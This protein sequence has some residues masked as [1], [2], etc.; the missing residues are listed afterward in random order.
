MMKNHKKI[1]A[2]LFVTAAILTTGCTRTN[3]DGNTNTN[4]NGTANTTTNADGTTNNA[5]NTDGTTPKE[6][7]LTETEARKIALERAGLESATFTQQ[8]YDAYDGEYEFE[9]YANDKE[10]DC[11]VNAIDGTITEYDEDIVNR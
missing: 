1:I 10:Y 8:K 3:T 9:F 2:A 6:P 4:N 5:T 11:D 7:V